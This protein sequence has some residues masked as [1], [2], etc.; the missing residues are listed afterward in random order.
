[1]SSCLQEN[2]NGE[3]DKGKDEDEE[4]NDEDDVDD[5]D[6]TRVH[7]QSLPSSLYPHLC[8]T[9]FSFGFRIEYQFLFPPFF[10]YLIHILQ[11]LDY[12]QHKVGVWSRKLRV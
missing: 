11:I 8:T 10:E 4:K 1:M 6:D 3:D 12:T 9:F 2:E 5:D 7:F